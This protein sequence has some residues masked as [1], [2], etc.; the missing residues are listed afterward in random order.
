MAKLS[1]KQSNAA[2][3]APAPTNSGFKPKSDKFPAIPEG[4]Y[5]A[6]VVRMEHRYVDKSRTPWKK[7]NEEISIA[8]KITNG[9]YANRWFFADTP[10]YLDDSPGCRLRIWL[11]ELIGVD[12]LPDTFEFDTDELDEYLGFDCRI[13][14]NQYPTKKGETKNGVAEV[15]RSVRPNYDDN[16]F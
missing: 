8:F 15:L 5:D 3:S 13:R 1:F 2:D 7:H 12:K 6:E 4:V 11:Q 9:E 14:V 16:P 10:F